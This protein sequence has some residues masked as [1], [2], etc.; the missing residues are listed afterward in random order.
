MGGELLGSHPK[1]LSLRHVLLSKPTCACVDTI[2]LMLNAVWIVLL[3]AFDVIKAPVALPTDK[4]AVVVSDKSGQRRWAANWTMEPADR[5][6]RKAVR[7][8]ERGQGHMDPFAGEV[9]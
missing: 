6:G 9:R 3:V 2:Y 1:N 7:F 8:T 4:G 5:Q